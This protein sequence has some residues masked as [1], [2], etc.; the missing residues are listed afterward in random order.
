ML[1]SFL[2][3]LHTF[4]IPRIF[5]KQDDKSDTTFLVFLK[6]EFYIEFIVETYY[7]KLRTMF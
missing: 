3:T 1:I 4:M 2:V 5:Y 7:L 6:K